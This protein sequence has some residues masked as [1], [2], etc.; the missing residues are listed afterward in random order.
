[1]VIAGVTDSGRRSF[2][3]DNP[4]Y[5]PAAIPATAYSEMQEALSTLSVVAT[6]VA[7]EGLP[8][9][10]VDLLVT[11]VIEDIGPRRPV[12]LIE[13]AARLPQH[14]TP[15]CSN[16]RDGERPV[17]KKTARFLPARG[18]KCRQIA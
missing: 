13:Q 12:G 3:S 16:E 5:E 11:T 6:V 10:L 17:S 15:R 7:L 4:D 2:V 9:A 14:F 1:M 8:D 18:G